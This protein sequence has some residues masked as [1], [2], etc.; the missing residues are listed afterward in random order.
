MQWS[1]IYMEQFGR[2][3]KWERIHEGWK[4]EKGTSKL[5]IMDCKYA[6]TELQ[7]F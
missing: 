7:E 6:A 1:G 5:L 4:L 3:S 2:K